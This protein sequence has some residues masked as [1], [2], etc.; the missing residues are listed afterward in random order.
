MIKYIIYLLL[1]II[2]IGLRAQTIY[3]YEDEIKSKTS[4]VFEDVEFINSEDDI[5]LSGTLILPKCDFNKII[6]I[7]A[8]AGKDTRHAHYYLAEQLLENSIG[9]FRFDERGV[10]KSEG[11]YSAG[12]TM[13]SIDLSFAISHLRKRSELASKQIGVMGHSLG[14]LASIDNYKNNS[15]IDFLIQFATP[16][17]K[18]G[19]FIK[20]Q[21][22]VDNKFFT[23][24]KGDSKQDKLQIVELVHA[25]ILENE[26]DNAQEIC[27]KAK[28]AI[29]K[30]YGFK[31]C[32]YGG[33][34]QPYILETVRKDYEETY[35]TIDIPTLYIIGSKDQFVSPKNSIE[36]LDEF[37]NTNIRIRQFEGLN[38]YLNKEE[39]TS[40]T[41]SIYKMERGAVDEILNWLSS[42]EQ[43]CGSIINLDS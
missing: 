3:S 31:K 17:R 27:K 10:G 16:V 19:A 20:H 30:K 34:I 21:I 37:G 40:L 22:N 26:E 24:I 1:F 12:V 29:G 42:F 36:L 33:Y 13:L 11:E 9:V 39:L 35:R 15:Q 38:H 25:L 7:V 32:Q 18:H 5:K 14:G 41:K 4:F 28:K 2:S 43:N 23:G 6:I 8:G